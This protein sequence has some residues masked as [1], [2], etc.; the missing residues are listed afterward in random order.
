MSEK[1]D[2]IVPYQLLLEKH[3]SEPAVSFDIF[4]LNN[5]LAPDQKIVYVLSIPNIFITA[6]LPKV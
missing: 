2:K 3:N 5:M 4:F 6:L 1:C